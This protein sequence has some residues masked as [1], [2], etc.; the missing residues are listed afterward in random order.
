MASN[1]RRI[2]RANVLSSVASASAVKYSRVTGVR[3]TGARWSPNSA[4]ARDSATMAESGI[5]LLECVAVPLAV[6]SR[7]KYTLSCRVTVMSIGV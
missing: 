3:W 6:R 4:T 7:L 1:I 2:I 5:G